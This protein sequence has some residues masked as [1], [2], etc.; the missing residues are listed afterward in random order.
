MRIARQW[1]FG[2]A[3]CL[4]TS[5]AAAQPTG[6]PTEDTAVAAPANPAYRTQLLQLISDDA[7][8]RADLKRDYTP[9][10]LQHDTVSL[11]AF[12]RELRMA[13]K[14][15]LGRL[16][17]L[18]RRQGFPDAHAVGADVAHAAFLI[19]QRINE[20]GFRADFQRG[21]DAAVQREAYSRA[22]QTL[23][24]D[25]SRALSAKR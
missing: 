3:L 14:E 19:A 17:E 25:R 4:L 13:Q 24:A 23:F 1:A 21:I 22:D 9:Q 11:R 10:R 7:Q 20:P 5:I 15:S 6:T 16:T 2:A 12:A 8:A 18:I